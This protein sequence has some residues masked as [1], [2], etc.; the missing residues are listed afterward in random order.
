MA[1][2]VIAL[3][4]NQGLQKGWLK[5]RWE[6]ILIEECEVIKQ[7]ETHEPSQLKKKFLGLLALF[8]LIK[9]HLLLA[10]AELNAA[11]ILEQSKEL[12]NDNILIAITVEEL[13]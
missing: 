5:E 12:I 1:W 2:L 4:F 10:L 3:S 8:N 9:V 6:L 13:H 7:V 11:N